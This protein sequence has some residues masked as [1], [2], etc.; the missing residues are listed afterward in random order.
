MEKFHSNDD[1]NS[2]ISICMT[3]YHNPIFDDIIASITF[4]NKNQ[5][6]EYLN[7]IERNYIYTS[8]IH[9]FHEYKEL[10]LNIFD[11]SQIKNLKGAFLEV[12]TQTILEC[13]YHPRI[14]YN[15]CVVG[16]GDW[17]SDLTVDIAIECISKGLICECKVPANKF[18]WNIFKNLLDI[19]E[20]SNNYFS[21]FAV[22][23]NNRKS[24]E[25]KKERIMNV[26]P[27]ANNLNEIHI[28]ARED[29]S[30]FVFNYIV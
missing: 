16:I 9:V 27:E 10:L 5:L 18:N 21:P 25:I 29:L 2:L 28:I 15:D 23:L 12:L 11:D 17:K 6:I 7:R 26:V 30:K 3:N 14:V 1:I 22:T 13:V 19:Y 20:K 4:S 24:I 8:K